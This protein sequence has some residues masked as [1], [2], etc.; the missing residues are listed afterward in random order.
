MLSEITDSVG[1]SG[2]DSVGVSMAPRWR[3]PRRDVLPERKNL[4][5]YLGFMRTSLG[6]SLIFSQSSMVLIQFS[7][8]HIS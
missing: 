4:M 6:N 5:V 2:K 7:A 3:R 8:Y 1:V